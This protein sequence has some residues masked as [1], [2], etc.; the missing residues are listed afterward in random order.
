MTKEQF[1]ERFL[2]IFLRKLNK[3]IDTDEDRHIAIESIKEFVKHE[4][5]W[6][7]IYDNF[8]AGVENGYSEEVQFNLLE[9]LINLS[10]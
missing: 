1:S 9:N 5:G 10:A 4:G 3:D 7:V 8:R 6:D 2:H